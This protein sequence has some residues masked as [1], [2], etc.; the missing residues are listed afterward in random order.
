MFPNRRR[1][2]TYPNCPSSALIKYLH[3]ST[4]FSTSYLLG[5]IADTLQ[6]R[7]FCQ[8]RILPYPQEHHKSMN[9]FIRPFTM[10]SSACSENCMKKYLYLSIFEFSINIECLFPRE[11]FSPNAIASLD[12]K[13][14]I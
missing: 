3:H 5:C 13:H 7:L 6:K 11:G 12:I 1:K 2:S 14:L 10:L 8:K 4:A 9:S